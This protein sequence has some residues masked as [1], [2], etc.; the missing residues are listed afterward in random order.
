MFTK[1]GCFL[2]SLRIPILENVHLGALREEV[3]ARFSPLAFL[4]PEKRPR[5]NYRP[6]ALSNLKL[7]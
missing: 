2:P 3:V 1:M 6:A 4:K 5:W 7:F